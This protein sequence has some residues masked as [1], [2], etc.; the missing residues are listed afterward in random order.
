MLPASGGNLSGGCNPA[1][2][3]SYDVISSGILLEHDFLKVHFIG[4]SPTVHGILATA[5]IHMS[6][7]TD[8][9][10]HGTL[11]ISQWE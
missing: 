9:H 11:L 2:S 6:V 5:D 3:S 8:L 4:W 10:L 1:G 7:V